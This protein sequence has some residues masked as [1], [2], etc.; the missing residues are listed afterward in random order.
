MKVDIRFLGGTVD[1][2]SDLVDFQIN[3]EKV[4]SGRQLI[5]SEIC[6]TMTKE[7]LCQ[8]LLVIFN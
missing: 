4:E 8:K 3:A 2:A 6:S 1:E 7:E 5:S